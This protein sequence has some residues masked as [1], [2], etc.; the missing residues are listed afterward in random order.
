MTRKTEVNRFE[1]GIGCTCI[2]PSSWYV[3]E[4]KPNDL[5]LPISQLN[6]S[7]PPTYFPC[8]YQHTFL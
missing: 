5:F 1:G 2:L 6:V 7:V 3:I 4:K 8:I